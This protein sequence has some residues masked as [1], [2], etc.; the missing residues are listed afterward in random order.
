MAETEERAGRAMGIA[1]APLFRQRRFEQPR[2]LRVVVLNE[3]HVGQAVVGP[4]ITARAA[5]N[6]YKVRRRPVPVGP[7][8][9]AT[10][11]KTRSEP[12][13]FVGGACG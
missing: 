6:P 7:M 8:L 9:C 10:S 11:S 4:R 13:R 3:S 2:R 12:R 1:E 5:R